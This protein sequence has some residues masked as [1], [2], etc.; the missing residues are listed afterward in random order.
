MLYKRRQHEEMQ[1]KVAMELEERSRSKSGKG[2]GQGC[3]KGVATGLWAE[4]QA[5]VRRG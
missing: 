1:G 3:A 2:S 4:Q 5:P